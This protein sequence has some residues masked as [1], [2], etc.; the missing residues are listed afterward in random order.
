MKTDSQLLALKSACE[1]LTKQFQSIMSIDGE[2]KFPDNPFD[3]FSIGERRFCLSQAYTIVL[4]HDEWLEKYGSDKAISDAVIEYDDCGRTFQYKGKR[5]STDYDSDWYYFDKWMEGAR[6]TTQEE[7]P[8]IHE[9]V[10]YVP[11][12]PRMDPS[13]LE[14]T[15]DLEQKVKS[16]FQDGDIEVEV[17]DE[18]T[19][20]EQSKLL[21][22]LGLPIDSADMYYCRMKHEHFEIPKVLWESYSKCS[23]FHPR[24]FTY[25]P[26]WSGMRITEILTAIS[27]KILKQMQEDAPDVALSMDVLIQLLKTF[28]EFADIELSKIKI[29]KKTNPKPSGC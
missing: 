7:E 1:E 27:L 28:K 23:D 6:P 14:E 24:V 5:I 10:P 12:I 18:Y 4:R 26:C 8:P 29:I 15:E 16:A 11:P 22:E 13:E 3:F 19:T 21:L 25:M 17:S 2:L 20:P 9:E